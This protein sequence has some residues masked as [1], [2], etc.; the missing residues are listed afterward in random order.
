MKLKGKLNTMSGAL[1]VVQMKEDVLKFPAAGTHLGGPNLDFQMEQFV[2]RRKS[3]GIH[4]IN[5]KRS[6][7]KLLLAAR[8]IVVIEN[9]ADASV[10]SSRSTGQ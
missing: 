4:I 8:A 10:I 9:S 7:E 6:W 3:D 1:D 2:Y 5:L